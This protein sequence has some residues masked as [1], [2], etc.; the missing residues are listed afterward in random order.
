[1]DEN[2]MF[3]I[4]WRCVIG[5]YY[6][7]NYCWWHG[8]VYFLIV[9]LPASDSSDNPLWYLGEQQTVSGIT[10]LR[11]YEIAIWQQYPEENVSNYSGVVFSTHTGSAK[12]FT[13]TVQTYGRDL[14]FSN[15]FFFWAGRGDEN[16]FTSN[17]FNISGGKPPAQATTSTPSTPESSSPQ[18]QNNGSEQGSPGLTAT[19]KIALGVGLSV[20]I[21][22]LAIA[23]FAAH[24]F[25]QWQR[26]K[27]TKGLESPRVKGENM[28]TELPTKYDPS[29][30]FEPAELDGRGF[31]RN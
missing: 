9:S 19:M 17:Y 8:P 27:R 28:R 13:W 14:E 16:N 4:F 18:P 7:H 10:E 22:F 24:K 23:C 5:R 6:M 1:M 11:D 2:L 3:L 15:V 20:G 30:F 21:I 29:R 26:L 25:L 12:N 31:S